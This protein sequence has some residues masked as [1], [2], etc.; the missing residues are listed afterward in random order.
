ELETATRAGIPAHSIVFTGPGKI[1]DELAQAIRV[2]VRAITVE[3]PAELARLM[4][5]AETQIGPGGPDQPIPVLLR[6]A[7]GGS[8]ETIRLV[9]DG[10]AG[11]FGMATDDLRASA[12]EVV[13]SARLELLGIH[14]FG[15]S[16]IVDVE[17]IERH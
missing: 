3:S 12:G 6:L 1:D 17:A 11:K 8:D 13:A 16:N 5:I 4:R 2:G 9:G 10:G 7:L 14:A 15:A